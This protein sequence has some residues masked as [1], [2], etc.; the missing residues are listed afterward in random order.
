MVFWNAVSISQ[1]PSCTRSC[2][3]L[4]FQRH[5]LPITMLFSASVFEKI[6]REEYL[7]NNCRTVF[8]NPN[9]LG[10]FRLP[11][12]KQG[13][14]S[15]SACNTICS[16]HCCQGWGGGSHGLYKYCSCTNLYVAIPR[17][18]FSQSM[19]VG[20]KQTTSY[21]TNIKLFLLKTLLGH[22]KEFVLIEYVCR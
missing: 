15:Q 17:S 22:T 6:V 20:K 5:Q 16:I 1:L 10:P 21:Y 12:P 2:R 4:H 19:F 3:I 8:F 13:V 9:Q 18:L 14:S 7:L 11:I